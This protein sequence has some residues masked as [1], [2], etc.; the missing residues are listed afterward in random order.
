MTTKQPTDRDFWNEKAK[1]FPRFSSDKH[2]YEARMLAL[3]REL[4]VDFANR[5]VLDIGCGTG[6][7]TI[8]IALEARH[9]FALDI[10]EEMLDILK[11][12]AVAQGLNNITYTLSDWMDCSLDD[13]CDIL[14]CSMSP[15]VSDDASREKLLTYTRA[16]VVFMGF[17]R[18]PPSDVM[19]GVYEHHDITP[20]G[21]DHAPHMREWLHSRGIIFRYRSVDDRWDVP[22]AR[23]ALVNACEL[24]VKR[25][26][27][28]PDTDFITRHV[29]RFKGGDDMYHEKTKFTAEVL[30]WHNS[31]GA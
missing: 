9:V 17:A 1:H 30:A 23:E 4:G 22:W 29:E 2:C 10:S 11:K 6:M 19:A 18:R 16:Q 26:G 7:Y 5:T 13:C 21:F 28:A 25:H 24:T 15:A 31:A 27:A 14:F 20:K 8:R 12:D 3:V